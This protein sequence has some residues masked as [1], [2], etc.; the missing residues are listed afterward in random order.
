MPRESGMCLP[1]VKTNN[2]VELCGSIT[3]ESLEGSVGAEIPR[4]LV[5]CC[6]QS[7]EILLTNLKISIKIHPSGAIP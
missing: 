7:S 2:V 6:L 3:N 1:R 5:W 4:K